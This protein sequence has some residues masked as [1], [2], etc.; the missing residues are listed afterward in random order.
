MSD[1]TKS[2][3][4][5]RPSQIGD[6]VFC[7]AGDDEDGNLKIFGMGTVTNFVV[8]KDG[9]SDKCGMAIINGDVVPL[10]VLD[11]GGYVYG[12]E[13]YMIMPDSKAFKDVHEKYPNH[14]TVDI[15]KLRQNTSNIMVLIANM[16]VG[17]QDELRKS[18]T[19]SQSL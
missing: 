12:S 5:S 14:V 10:I 7:I 15:V 2:R 1:D 13:C 16:M 9:I 6:R 4:A 8:P 17:G 3:P 11:E 18:D 19:E